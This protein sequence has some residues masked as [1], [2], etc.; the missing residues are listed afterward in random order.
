[1]VIENKPTS[2]SPESVCNDLWS[3]YIIDFSPAV[4]GVT[5][6]YNNSL[7]AQR[8]VQL[9][10]QLD[11]AI[12]T[13]SGGSHFGALLTGVDDTVLRDSDHIGYSG[14]ALIDAD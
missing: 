13:V 4:I 2:E 5:S 8:L 6:M 12:V 1:M 11:P 10:K 14:I 7:Q 9:A 3:R